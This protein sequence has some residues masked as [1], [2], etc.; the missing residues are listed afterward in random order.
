[1]RSYFANR[2]EAGRELATLLNA[3]AHRDDVRVLALPR[4]GVPVAFEVARAL[5]APLDVLVVRKLGVPMQP[6]L[7]MGAIASGDAFYLDRR[8]VE[9][10]GVSKDALAD[11]IARERAEL[12]RRE[13]L[14]RGTNAPLDAHDRVTIVVDDGMATGSTMRA[15]AMS[16]RH[17]HPARI[18]A[19]LP[20]APLD[21]E[22]RIEDVV[23]EFVAVT[24]PHRFL[25]VGQFYDDFDQTSDEEVR[26]L[27][28][29]ARAT[30][31]RRD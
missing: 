28:Q 1:M 19:A 3:Y 5:A 20:V 4:G 31:A 25:G 30:C 26:A 6:E 18:V 11:V 8:M 24:R 21:A 15:A 29:E 23:D 10:V 9:A 7:A 12:A 27:L 13:R 2:R 22:A 14:Y 17:A 16:L